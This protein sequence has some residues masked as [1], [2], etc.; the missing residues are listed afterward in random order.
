MTTTPADLEA[1]YAGS[2]YTILGAGGDMNEWIDGITDMFVERGIGTPQAWFTTTGKAINDFAEARGP[3]PALQHFQ[4]ELTV[5]MFKLDGLHGGKLAMFK[6][7]AGDRWFD[8]VVDNMVDD[9]E[10]EG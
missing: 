1:A 10:D 7:M 8:D 3:V 9:N 5:L 4:D 6:V 2:Y